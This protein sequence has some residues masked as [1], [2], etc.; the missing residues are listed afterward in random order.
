[1][2]KIINKLIR[3]ITAV[4]SGSDVSQVQSGSVLG[5]EGNPALVPLMRKAAADGCVL[6]KN[7]NV[8]P[9]SKD[10]NIAVFGRVQY[11][12]FNV[13][14]GSGGDVCTPY[15]QNLLDGFDNCKELNINED[16]RNAYVEWC[17]KKR[18][19]PDPGFWARWPR[20]YEEMPL[21]DTFVA[22]AAKK[23]N[24]AV[25]VIGRSAGED[26]DNVL[27][28]GSFFLTK[29]EKKMLDC[30]TSHFDKV[31][32]ILDIGSIMDF[33][34]I[35]K[36]Q[37]KISAVL[38]AWQ[39][40][41]ESGNAICDILS[42]KVNPSGK[43]TDT[44]ARQYSDYPGADNFGAKLYNNYV[45]DIF[46]G[47]RYFETFAP[48]KVL[49]EFGFG[50]S[51]TKFSI[52]CLEASEKDGNIT[53]T[54]K[55]TNK[56]MLD[57]SEVVQLYA[58]CPNGKL[59]KAAKVLVAFAKTDVIKPNETQTLTLTAD[60]YLFA[61]F[62]DSGVT[63]NK[64]CYILEKGNYE[65]YLGNSVKNCIKTLDF[66]LDSDLILNKLEEITAVPDAN[67][68]ERFTATESNGKTILKKEK[69]PIGTVDL[70]AKI[71]AE[72][73]P[74]TEITG[75]KGYKL[76]DVRN[77]KVSMCD[78]VAQLSLD[79]LEAISRG[80]GAMNSKEGAK[81]NAGSLGGVCDSLRKKGIP[82]MITT[83]GPS[84][85]RLLSACSLLP[86]GTALACTWDV[87]LI[88]KVYDYMGKEMLEK[89]SDVLLAP[90]MNIHRNP[91]CGR[92]FEYFSEDPLISGRFA[93]A[94][95]N[96]IQKNGV[97]ACPKHF[98]CNNQEYNRIYNDSLV[99]ERA[100][101]EIYLK[102][103]ELCIKDSK[104][105][106]IMTSYNKI[107]GVWSH[108]NYQLCTTVLRSEWG[109]TGNVMTDWWMRYSASPEFPELS[110]NAYRVR[111]QVDV[112]MPGGKTHISKTGEKSDGTLL[113]T[114]GKPD[115]ITLGELQ[116]TAKNV[117]NY[118][119]VSGKEL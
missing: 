2:S 16:V 105:M 34:E 115:G 24:K 108:Y 84:G 81:G 53:V 74:F 48:E 101:R 26:R 29:A 110:S 89:G 88:E 45:E 104:P 61:S 86:N 96:G 13:G 73:P 52:E 47:Y 49:Y 60:R 31:V 107:N 35:E 63:G 5:G 9:F 51:Y 87:K 4:A 83:D 112:L 21:N 6:L 100:L 40:G 58:K 99:S 97:S 25:V 42:G 95:V 23:S 66:T 43:L 82:P 11:N 119:I 41:M 54:A 12:Y 7:N 18:N 71:I 76:A 55:V 72:L 56:G 10:D 64:N 111:A 14:N 22:N 98:A 19:I 33:A 92:N 27:E 39:G 8:L 117:L 77:G 44:I 75:D 113:A 70:K 80:E 65:F 37:D 30:V 102:G 93:A 20:F 62:D 3:K 50:L 116:R 68:F 94:V 106:N 36:Y 1:M 109:Y 85:I 114:Y 38:I 59:G 90:G 17:E 103:F 32:L 15:K 78:F 67:T 46:V 79:E 118:I 57:G 69:T 28:E 91:L